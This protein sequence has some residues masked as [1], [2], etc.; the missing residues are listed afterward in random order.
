M[1]NNIITP[2][3]IVKS[4]FQ[5]GDKDYKNLFS[6]LIIRKEFIKGLDGLQEFSHLYVLYWMHDASR[7]QQLTLKV[8]P[9]GNKKLP[10]LGFFAT[11]TPD[12]PNPVGLTLVEL[13]RVNKNQ[14]TVRGLDALD[15]SPIID[16]KPYDLWDIE[17]YD[18]IRIPQWWKK[19]RPK[20][21]TKWRRMKNFHQ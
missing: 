20:T 10:L 15:G 1:L 18:K 19:A 14:L 11:R 9:W 21:W 6:D 16:I 5:R 13:V 12:R 7:G 8:H 2:I 17:E 4:S 3:G